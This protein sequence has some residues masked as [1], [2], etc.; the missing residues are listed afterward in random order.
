MTTLVIARGCMFCLFDCLE[1]N[2]L[3]CLSL[4]K[5]M[6]YGVRGKGLVMFKEF[7]MLKEL[8]MTENSKNFQV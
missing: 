6:G 5:L 3:W 1:T 2:F 7:V 4:N 8:V